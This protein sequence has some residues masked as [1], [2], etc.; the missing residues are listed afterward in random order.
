MRVDGILRAQVIPV[1]YEVES[2]RVVGTL[3]PVVVPALLCKRELPL[4]IIHVLREL[5]GV[6]AGLELLMAV[7]S[8]RH[9]AS[10]ILR[11]Y[12]QRIVDVPSRLT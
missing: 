10:T 1:E 7:A 2:F 8:E 11:G 5:I 3:S 6:G 9:S 12:L 4:I